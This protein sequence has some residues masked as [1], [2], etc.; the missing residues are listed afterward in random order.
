MRIVNTSVIPGSQFVHETLFQVESSKLKRMP[1]T[2]GAEKGQA[3]WRQV[4]GVQ[5]A[6]CCDPLIGALI[7]RLFISAE[8]SSRGHSLSA[9]LS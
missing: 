7:D 4:N 3:R 1:S 5:E 9:L 8:Y 6:A 2:G